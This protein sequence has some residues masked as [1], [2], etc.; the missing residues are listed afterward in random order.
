MLLLIMKNYAIERFAD[1]DPLQCPCWGQP[2]SSC[3]SA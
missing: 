3:G 2:C 1:L